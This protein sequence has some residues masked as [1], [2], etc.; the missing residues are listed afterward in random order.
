M[1]KLH[2]VYKNF[3]IAFMQND[4]PQDY[5]NFGIYVNYLTN[6]ARDAESGPPK[7]IERPYLHASKNTQFSLG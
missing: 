2:K 7:L 3:G 5:E 4:E 6:S 1:C